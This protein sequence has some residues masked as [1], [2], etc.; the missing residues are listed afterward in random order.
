MQKLKERWGISSNFQ[1][2]MILIVFS[3]TGSCA[4]A[5]ADPVMSFFDLTKEDTSPWLYWPLRIFLIFPLYQVLLVVFG[6]VF[7]Q[8][9]FFWAFEKKM[10]RRMGLGFLLTAEEGSTNRK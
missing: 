6:F 1:L 7:G 4:V 8:F 10:L 3:V 2:V 9:K 5:L